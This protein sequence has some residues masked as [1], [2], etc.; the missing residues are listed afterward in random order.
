M[1]K[2]KSVRSKA[3]KAP[4]EEKPAKEPAPEE[5]KAPAGAGGG[6]RLAF[7]DVVPDIVVK[8]AERGLG[9]VRKCLSQKVFETGATWLTRLGSSMS[10]QG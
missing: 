9:L 8:L 7:L 6:D 1:A 10:G 5:A 3:A 4:K 2:K